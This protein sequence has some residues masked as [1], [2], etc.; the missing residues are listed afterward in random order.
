MCTRKVIEQYLVLKNRC[1]G[2]IVEE[3]PD[4]HFC[5][6]ACDVPLFF[7][8]FRLLHFHKLSLSILSLKLKK[9]CVGVLS[10]LIS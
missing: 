8:K 1:L 2:S 10:F 7:Y 3:K 9:K 5:P 4:F 6:L